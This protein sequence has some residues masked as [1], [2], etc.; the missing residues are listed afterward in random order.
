MYTIFFCLLN[1]SF[2]YS[3]SICKSDLRPRILLFWLFRQ[4]AARAVIEI[5]L[6]FLPLNVFFYIKWAL[7]KINR[8]LES[9][10]TFIFVM[11]ELKKLANIKV[12]KISI[13]PIKNTFLV[14]NRL[15]LRILD[16]NEKGRVA[17]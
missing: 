4:L 14:Q 1:S 5:S 2:K 12:R 13:L 7:Y 11:F 16:V 3:W 6:I 17:L 10:C 15:K 8:N 9:F